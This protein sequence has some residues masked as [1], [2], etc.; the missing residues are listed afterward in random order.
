[1]PVKI[2]TEKEL[3]DFAEKQPAEDMIAYIEKLA[4]IM[5][6]EDDIHTVSQLLDELQTKADNLAELL[7]MIYDYGTIKG[8]NVLANIL[9]INAEDFV[10]TIMEAKGSSRTLGIIQ[11]V[12]LKIILKKL[13]GGR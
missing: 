6:E 9:R 8:I 2:I 5:E 10:K 3:A 11:A 4:S 1:M 7:Y 13:E 12:V